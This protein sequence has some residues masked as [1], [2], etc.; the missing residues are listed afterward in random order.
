MHIP[1]EEYKSILESMPILCVD[2]I[3]I[4]QG[5][6]LLVK[7]KNKPLEGKFWLPGGRVYRG[8]RLEQAV[9]RKMLQEIGIQVKVTGFAGLHEYIYEENEYGLDYVHTLSA[10]FYASPLNT[11]VLLDKQS[12]SYGWFDTLPVELKLIK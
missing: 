4:H 7:R 9:V 3:I 10:V 5:R 2:C 6:Y 12:S 1:L 11:D 8:E